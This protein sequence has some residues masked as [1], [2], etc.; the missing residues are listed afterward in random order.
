MTDITIQ[1][2]RFLIDGQ[3]TYAG[4]VAVEGLLFNVR[5]VNATYIDLG[6][7]CDKIYPAYRVH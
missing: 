5:T 4:C 2:T 3:P 6:R 1:D 7:V